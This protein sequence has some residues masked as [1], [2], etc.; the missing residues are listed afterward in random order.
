MK[1]WTKLFAVLFSIAL[2][3]FILIPTAQAEIKSLV[4]IYAKTPQEMSRL[5]RALDVAGK[6]RGEW[7]DVVVTPEKLREI[8]ATGLRTE[9]I[10][11]DVEAYS[12]TVKGFYHT[13]PGLVSDL[14]AIAASYP[15]IA[16][17]DTVG[18]SY[19]GRPLL[20]RGSGRDTRERRR[21]RPSGSSR[22][23]CASWDQWRRFPGPLRC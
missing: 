6:S 10:H 11:E 8:Q 23:P 21:D 14:Q 13:F 3:S 1:K 5:P 17:L 2:L 15:S 9:I 20:V 16:R 12:K 4:R 18:T 19:E 7:I 22:R